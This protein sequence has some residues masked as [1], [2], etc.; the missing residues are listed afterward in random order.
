MKSATALKLTAVEN[1]R[2]ATEQAKDRTLAAIRRTIA[3]Y[4]GVVLARGDVDR[5][6]DAM[7]AMFTGSLRA[8][9]SVT[10][11]TDLGRIESS[12]IL[13]VLAGQ[14]LLRELKASGQIS[15]PEYQIL[16]RA[17]AL[18]ANRRCAGS[19]PEPVLGESPEVVLFL[20]L[21]RA[22]SKDLF[23]WSAHPPSSANCLT[24]EQIALCFGVRPTLSHEE[25]VEYRAAEWDRFKKRQAEFGRPVS[26]ECFAKRAHTTR[27]TF[28]ANWLGGAW[29]D[30]S[31]EGARILLLLASPVERWSERNY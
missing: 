7:V 6:T 1:I 21:D 27:T 28:Y 11:Y 24:I 29:P 5:V 13:P 16:E 25:L 31:K 9:C 10:R 19:W 8:L 26:A 20:R 3:R 4:I 14:T 30:N 17:V 18:L 12:R 15:L 22:A 23:G 2:T